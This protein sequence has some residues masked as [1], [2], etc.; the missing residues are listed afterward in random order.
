MRAL[1][2]LE[3]ESVIVKEHFL[4]VARAGFLLPVF[5]TTGQL[6]VDYAKENGFTKRHIFVLYDIFKFPTENKKTPQEVL[7]FANEILYQML[8]RREIYEKL[9]SIIAEKKEKGIY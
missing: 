7:D 1:D 3:I 9:D 6:N 5:D 8:R 2:F 4:E